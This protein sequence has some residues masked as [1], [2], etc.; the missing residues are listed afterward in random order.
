M[1][2]RHCALTN[3]LGKSTCTRSSRRY[4]SKVL[5]CTAATSSL[6][7]HICDPL[8]VMLS[9]VHNGVVRT[10]RTS[11][12][13]LSS[14]RRTTTILLPSSIRTYTCAFQQRSRSSPL[15]STP[16]ATSH[17][18]RQPRVRSYATLPENKVP[19][20][21]AVLGGGL[22]G[23]TTA[24]YL[25][26]FNPDANITIYE[27]DER[28]GGWVDT[29]RISVKTWDGKDATI[30]FDRGARTVAPQSHVGRW[31]DFILYEMV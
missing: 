27:A 12:V 26:V 4:Y 14:L 16:H 5:V 22:T 20:D 29:E 7:G 6:Q 9:R 3:H 13:P 10:S 25:T 28:L 31:D 19:Q 18:T 11:R 30:T 17:D 15:L 2:T 1:T 8:R 23:L 24:H 21:I